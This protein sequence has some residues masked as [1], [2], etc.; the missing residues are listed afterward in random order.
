MSKDFE[1]YLLEEYSNIAKAHFKTMETITSF[2]RYYLIIMALPISIV[3]MFLNDTNIQKN[4]THIIAPLYWIF[5]IVSLSGFC[6]MLYIVNLRLDAILYARSIN[7]I[8]KYFY[9]SSTLNEFQRYHSKVLPQTAY[10]PNYHEKSY[11]WPVI[12]TFALINS[13]YFFYS[14]KEMQ[15]LYLSVATLSYSS[16]HFLSYLWY[17]GHREMGY[18]RSH[19]IG[20][21]IDGVLNEHRRHFCDFIKRNSKGEKIVNEDDIKVIPV[22]ECEELKITRKDE[23]EVFNDPEYWTK[24]PMMDG[25][26]DILK[27]MR[28]QLKLKVFIFTHRDWPD[29]KK[30][31]WKAKKSIISSWKKSLVRINEETV[32]KWSF[33]FRPYL[34]P[35]RK[36]IEQITRLWLRGNNIKHNKLIVEK[37]N[38]D[39]EGPRRDNKNRFYI[40]RKKK[41][42]F[43]VEDDL[44][45]ARKL[46]YICDYVFLLSHPYNINGYIPKNVIRVDSWKEIYKWIKEI[47]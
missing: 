37:G 23:K 46:A 27:K 9:D 7:L 10:Q 11:F 31:D 38:E 35:Q 45:K 41:I 32:G 12:C 42:K 15:V 20:V 28:N 19:I 16:L 29:I 8:R 43:F 4:T 30:L 1:D 24:M 25:V 40:G 34:L 5:L 47:A 6:V 17:A 39:I 14:F 36:Y 26:D 3:A 2:F 13:F 22:H 21:D 18:L 33:L 44:L